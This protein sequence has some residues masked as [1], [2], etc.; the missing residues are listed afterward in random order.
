MAKLL[1]QY[2]HS[3]IEQILDSKD[4]GIIVHYQGLDSQEEYDFRTKLRE[5]EARMRV[6]K[7]SIARVYCKGKGMT[8]SLEEVFVGPIALITSVEETGTINVAR[9][10]LDLVKEQKKI[11]VQ[12][13]IFDGEVLPANGVEDL[14]RMPTKEQLLSQLAG[15]LKA[16]TKKFASTIY[17]INARFAS[18]L[19][20]L[21]SKRE[22]DGGGDA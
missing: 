9:K 20:A 12:G 14:S 13:A 11:K 15:V 7:A 4:G 10:V 3:E 18:V 22:K 17:Q 1:K 2:L 5:S 19:N 16:P 8:G 21:Q 6:V